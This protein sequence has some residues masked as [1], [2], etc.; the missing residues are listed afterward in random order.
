MNYQECILAICANPED[1]APRKELVNL[2]RGPDPARAMFIEKQLQ[3]AMFRRL[4]RYE[5]PKPHERVIPPPGESAWELLDKHKKEWARDLAFYMSED[6]RHQEIGFDRGLPWSCKLSPWM[7]LEQGEHILAHI[8]PLRGVWFFDDPWDDLTPFP[9][10]EIAA[11]PLLAHFDSIS[12]KSCNVKDDDVE[13]FAASPHLGRLRLLNIETRWET[14]MRSLEALAAHPLTRRCLRIKNGL[15]AEDRGEIGECWV[16][17]MMN[18]KEYPYG[19]STEG[20]ALEKKYGYLPWLHLANKPLN[21]ADATY[22]VEQR[23]L[24][25]FEPGSPPDAPTPI[26]PGFPP[27]RPIEPRERADLY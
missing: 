17:R 19:M 23:V 9:M 24:P 2:L 22:W 26:G 21:D 11:S 13:L 12:F 15:V 18:Y 6:R 20:H 4:R 27:H 25:Q 5:D 1:D 8:A 14:S 3:E 7:F 16:Q 10:K